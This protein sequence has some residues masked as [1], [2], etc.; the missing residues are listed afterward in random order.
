MV[1]GVLPGKQG[2]AGR[3]FFGDREIEGGHKLC[4]VRTRTYE[5][6]DDL[7]GCAI[8]VRKRDL[9]TS[10]SITTHLFAVCAIVFQSEKKKTQLAQLVRGE[11]ETKNLRDQ[12]FSARVPRYLTLALRSAHQ[13]EVPLTRVVAL[14]GFQREVEFGVDGFGWVSEYIVFMPE[15]VGSSHLHLRQRWKT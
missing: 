7:E 5:A 3:C 9:T 6:P 14:V 15:G 2:I 12:L 13:I 1:V 4:E 11:K 10:S 8:I